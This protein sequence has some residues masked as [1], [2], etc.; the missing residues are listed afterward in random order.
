MKKNGFQL[1]FLIGFVA[2]FIFGILYLIKIY[3]TSGLFLTRECLFAEYYVE[4]LGIRD[5]VTLVKFCFVEVRLFFLMYHG[6]VVYL[7]K[8]RMNTGV[9]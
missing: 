9:R 3:G 7:T 4:I 1:C 2:N 6:T 8:A 5:I